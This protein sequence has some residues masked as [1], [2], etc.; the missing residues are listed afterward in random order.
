MF[1]AE[2]G[3]RQH[4]LVRPGTLLRASCTSIATLVGT[5]LE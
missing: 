1:M 5:P 2:E 3:D 4:E